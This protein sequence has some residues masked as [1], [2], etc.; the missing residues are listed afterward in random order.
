MTANR[1]TL[2]FDL[3]PIAG[4]RFQPTGFPDLGAATFER[5][6]T[7]GESLIVESTQSMANRLE[8]T[9]WDSASNAPA[10]DVA[11]L[12]YVRVVNERGEFL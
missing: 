7:K 6:G 4:S 3:K 11:E 9:T 5:A 8:G 2:T 10:A 1:T 12:P